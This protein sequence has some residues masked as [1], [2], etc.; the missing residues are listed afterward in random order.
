VTEPVRP[1]VVTFGELLLR[2]SPPDDERFFESE[3][4]RATFGGAEANVAVALAHLGVAS[5][6]VTRLPTNLIGDRA[7]SAVAEEGVA[8]DHVLRGDERMGVYFVE[9]GADMNLTRLVYDRAGSAFSR[10]TS[11]DIDWSVV[12]QGATWFHG[13]GITPALGEGPATTLSAAYETARR[14]RV[15]RSIDLNYRPALWTGRDPRPLVTPL[16]EEIDLLIGNRDAFLQMLGVESE[17]DPDG[18][19]RRVTRLCGTLVD[20]FHCRRVAVT[21]REVISPTEHRWSAALFDGATAEL[22][23]S[24]RHDVQVVD[25]MG[26]GDC[27]AAGLIYAILNDRP[28]P[29]GVGFAVAASALTLSCHGDF[30]RLTRDEVERL[31]SAT[32]Q[33]R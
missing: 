33:A 1:R 21:R 24:R 15:R 4:V 3:M 8:V 28:A 23:Q 6:Y 18:G 31:L 30:T 13:T 17:D 19:A 16:V 9:P 27:F 22:V 7:L 29:E 25:R 5:E 14:L 20:R 11:A 12:L 26:G 10:L 32:P 2:L